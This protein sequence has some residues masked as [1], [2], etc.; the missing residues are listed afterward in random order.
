MKI[1]KNSLWLFLSATLMAG[2]FG[3]T[4]CDTHQERFEDPPWLGGS[5]IETLEK[6]GNYTIFLRLMDRAGYTEPITKQLFTL[7][8]PDDAAF[9]EYFASVG[10]SSVEDLTDE[11]ARQLFTLH[12]LRNPRSRYYLIYEYAWNEFQAPKAEYASLFHRKE[13]PSTSIPY[14]ETVRYVP[15][16]A[17]QELIIYTDNKNIPLFTT[18]W[19]GDYGGA[20][21]GS[22]YL[23]MYPGSKW[24]E[25]YAEG[26]NGMNWHNAMVI[27]NPEIPDELEV[28]TSSGFIYFLDRPVPP[29][30]S[31][32]EYMIANLDKY[33]LYYD[34]LQRFA[35]YVNSKTDEA[36]NVQW[37][38]TYELVFDLA[39]ERGPS[40][41][42][43]IPPQNMW[44]AFL[45]TD[46]MLQAYLDQT[47]YKYYNNIDSVPR[48]TLFYILQTQLSGSLVLRSK[49]ANGYFNAFGDPTDLKPED[50]LWGY[51][52]SNGCVYQ[53]NKI[54]EPNVFTTVAG[55]LFFDKDY[56]TLLA[57]LNQAN[58]LTAISNPDSDVTLFATTNDELEEY[59]IRY[60]PLADVVEFRGPVDGKWGPMKETML[61]E[62]AQ[63]QIY[64][65]ILDLS[66]SGGFVET[67]SGNYI[68]YGNNQAGAGE[69]QSYEQPATVL[70]IVENELNGYLVKVDNPIGSRIV[71]GQVL[72]CPYG[73]D[74]CALADPDF[75]EFSQLLIDLRLLDNRNKDA[76]TKESIPKLKFLA[77]ADYWTAFIPDNAAMA[78][79]RLE[80]IIPTEFP[81]S[82]TGQDSLQKFVMYHFVV[83]DVLF[84]DGKESGE[85]NTNHTYKDTINDVTVNAPLRVINEPGNMSLVDSTG[86][87]VPVP[88]A[89]ANRLVQL[90]VVHKI[91][92]V[93]KYRDL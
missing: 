52:C 30:P 85:F 80:G 46:D 66:G 53:A 72:T 38:K 89:S 7:F 68:Q 59:G 18:E 41:N 34:L 48:T 62:F 5:S 47:V 86:Q 58:M 63:D 21:D 45:P 16:M 78:Q 65:G 29:M 23:F 8:V 61:T 43:V 76:T 92:S 91:G 81:S 17:G 54:L 75:S 82:S 13:T 22:D 32:E 12:V 49:L 57:V 2:M 67:N 24:E 26:M 44:T 19:F 77:A 83:G 60:D 35:N 9:E 87:V 88:H 14:K 84:D 69:N 71:M 55:T 20:K 37:Q 28:R 11:E 70:E 51:M 6:R 15:G 50:L 1:M 90:G 40:T 73:E 31:I 4:G 42:T 3:I 79:A 64:A 10:I 39:K 25:G 33:G 93:L 56:S 74:D 36:R 27:P